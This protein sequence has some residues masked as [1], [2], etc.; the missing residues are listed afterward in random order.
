MLSTSAWHERVAKGMAKAKT[1]K[2]ARARIALVLSFRR[3]HT[4]LGIGILLCAGRRARG[5]R[6][7]PPRPPRPRL[8]ENP[9]P[10]TEQ[11]SR[12]AQA[13][14]TAAVAASWGRVLCSGLRGS[15]KSL[16]C[17]LRDPAPG[18]PVYR[19]PGPTPGESRH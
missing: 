1:A 11:C 16:L 10:R 12:L 5:P 2:T 8:T 19:G 7:R 9:E 15:E 3:I 14:E 6:P 13:G 18:R 4:G 17:S